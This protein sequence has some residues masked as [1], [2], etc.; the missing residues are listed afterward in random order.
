MPRLTFHCVES[1][2]GV[3]SAVRVFL[4]LFLLFSTSNVYAAE[5]PRQ[6]I[7]DAGRAVDTA[8]VTTFQ[9]LVDVDA[10]LEQALDILVRRASDPQIARDLPPMLTLL[11]SQAAQREG[12]VR[13]LLLNEAR[14]FVLHGVSSGAFA[15]RQP[16]RDTAKGLL[17]PLF[18][19]ASKGRKEVRNVGQ[20]RRDG[21]GWLVPFM[22]HDGGNGETYA[23]TGRVTTT[24]DGFCLTS[25]ANMED[26]LT[27]VV[28][29]H[30][31]LEP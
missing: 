27:R 15:G 1:R 2:C 8:D 4:L 17:T 12:S 10:V 20:A 30:Q 25:L 11:F 23:V 6:C 26:L 22:V 31:N 18:A 24:A 14:M 5:S 9:K 19:D 29:E 7:L 13:A 3:L 28:T 21:E 16:V